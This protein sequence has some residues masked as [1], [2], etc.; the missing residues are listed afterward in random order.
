MD[1]HYDNG[2]FEIKTKDMNFSIIENMY[3]TG[4]GEGLQCNSVD[5]DVQE[6]VRNACASIY[7]MCVILTDILKGIE[8]VN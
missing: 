1:I 3:K 8:E 5:K 4:N 6:M 7:S 2:M